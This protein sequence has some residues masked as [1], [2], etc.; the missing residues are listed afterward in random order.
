M[1]DGAFVDQV[2]AMETKA[3]QLGIGGKLFYLFPS[4]GATTT[5]PSTAFSE[6][7]SPRNLAAAVAAVKD[8]KVNARQMV[9]SQHTGQ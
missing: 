9:D 7:L 8:G 1:K 3:K 6:F 2:V 4:G 5:K